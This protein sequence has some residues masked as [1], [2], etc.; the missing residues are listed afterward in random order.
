MRSEE[1]MMQLILSVAEKNSS[2]RGVI[3][4]GSRVNRNVTPDPFQDYDIV[5][6]VTEI[7]AFIAD[8]SW[9]DVFGKRL[10]MQLPDEMELYDVDHKPNAKI[11]LLNAVYGWEPDRSY[12]ISKK[13]S[14]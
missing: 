4:N 7:T 12:I 14:S 13:S 11:L 10:I 2:V 5:Y 1:E 6:V 8:H 9:V 3:M